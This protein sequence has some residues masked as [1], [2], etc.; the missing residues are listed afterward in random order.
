MQEWYLKRN[1]TAQNVTDIT[2]RSA[3]VFRQLNRIVRIAMQTKV[4]KWKNVN[5][6]FMF[7]ANTFNSRNRGD[8]KSL[9]DTKDN[10]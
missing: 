6:V 10:G 5:S 1:L 3:A 8:F 9:G 7:L 4:E 2:P